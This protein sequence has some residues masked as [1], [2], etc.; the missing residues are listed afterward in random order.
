VAGLAHVFRRQSDER[1]GDGQD[2]R[3]GHHC[4][5]GPQREVGRCCGGWRRWRYRHTRGPMWNACRRGGGKSDRRGQKDCQ[6][7]ERREC[8]TGG[9]DV[10]ACAA[11]LRW[12]A[13]MD[14]LNRSLAMW[15]TYR[16][17]CVVRTSRAARSDRKVLGSALE[18]D[19]E[20][21]QTSGGIDKSHSPGWLRGREPG[22]VCDGA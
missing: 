18:R 10:A 14:H 1:S 17:V 20:Q 12:C 21:R 19:L 7:A 22:G 13:S 15:E 5:D 8:S 6:S 11:R 16:T 4:H 9:G 3:C 2:D